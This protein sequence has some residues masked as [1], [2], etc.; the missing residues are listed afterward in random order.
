MSLWQKPTSRATDINSRAQC[1]SKDVQE[2]DVLAMIYKYYLLV[3]ATVVGADGIPNKRYSDKMD[4]KR[5]T[6]GLAFLPRLLFQQAW[7]LGP[8]LA[9]SSDEYN[10]PE[11]YRAYSISNR[12]PPWPT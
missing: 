8:T 6:R 3:V 11:I 5:A 12:Y 7:H 2:K 1:E 9:T 10:L 4:A